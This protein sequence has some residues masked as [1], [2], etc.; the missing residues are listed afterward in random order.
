MS[1]HCG[2]R[3]FGRVG[4]KKCALVLRIPLQ[5]LL[6]F[7]RSGDGPQISLDLSSGSL[8]PQLQA[9]VNRCS[10][11]EPATFPKYWHIENH[12]PNV[13]PKVLAGFRRIWEQS[14]APKYWRLQHESAFQKVLAGLGA[15]DLCFRLFSL[16]DP[17][18]QR[19]SLPQQWSMHKQS[20]LRGALL[21]RILHKQY[22]PSGRCA[23]RA[24]CVNS[25]TPGP[26]M[27]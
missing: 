11:K 1:P 16:R 17:A 9:V 15:R 3:E 10:R 13:F 21:R 23:P 2:A 19:Q 18:E 7:S 8:D 26:Q 12:A 20:W 5:G 27:L 25:R 22:H 4:S 6:G 24:S 14:L